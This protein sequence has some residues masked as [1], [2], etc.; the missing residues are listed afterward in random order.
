[1]VIFVTFITV[2]ISK[3]VLKVLYETQWPSALPLIPSLSKQ[4][5]FNFFLICVYN[6][7][8]L[9]LPDNLLNILL[10]SFYIS[11]PNR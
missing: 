7:R 1:M 3:A 9:L 2:K 8:M 6:V 10:T 5:F 4:L 11:S